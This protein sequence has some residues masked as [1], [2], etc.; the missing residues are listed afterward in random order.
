MTMVRRRALEEVGRLVRVVHLRGRRARPA[1]DRDAATRPSTSTEI[2]GHG[3]TP[4]HFTAFK[5]QRFRWA[6]GAMQILKAHCRS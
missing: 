2:F 3:L 5:S 4:G 6:F 1:P